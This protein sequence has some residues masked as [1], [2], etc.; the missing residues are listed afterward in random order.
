MFPLSSGWF[1]FP[2]T[3]Q[4]SQHITF[5]LIAKLKITIKSLLLL[6]LKMV[7]IKL[8]IVFILAAA[9]IAAIALPV[10]GGVVSHCLVGMA[11]ACGDGDVAR[12]DRKL[13]VG[14]LPVM[15]T[16]HFVYSTHSS[17]SSPPHSPVIAPPVSSPPSHAVRSP[18][19]A[20][21]T[22]RN[23]GSNPLPQHPPSG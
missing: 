4:D 3:S 21:T 11:Q 7:Q 12:F 13:F 20:S 2:H 14:V 18:G 23:V 19:P 17:E 10:P 1:S 16:S 8:P 9:A 22:T 15:L 5:A 6:N